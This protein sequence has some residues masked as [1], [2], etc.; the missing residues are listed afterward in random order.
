MKKTTTTL[1]TLVLLSTLAL[2][3]AARPGDG[4]GRPG[5]DGVFR[6]PGG[7]GESFGDRALL[8]EEERELIILGRLLRMSPEELDN[9]SAAIEK[10]RSMDEAEKEAL[11]AKL[12]NLREEKRSQIQERLREWQSIPPEQRREIGQAMRN[13]TPEERQALREELRDLEPEERVARIR[14]IVGQ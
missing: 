2:P 14:E 11:N 10:V 7:P 9:L 3:L 6:G 12:E 4:P 13:L 5:P 1:I 8:T